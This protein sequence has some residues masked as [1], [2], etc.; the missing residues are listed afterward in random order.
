MNKKIKLV[1]ASG[2]AT[3]D[4]ECGQ[5]F[6]ALGLLET[7]RWGRLAVEVLCE[8]GTR[9]A[10]DPAWS[11][12][13]NYLQKKDSWSDWSLRDHLMVKAADDL[14][15]QL[16]PRVNAHLESGSIMDAIGGAKVSEKTT[17]RL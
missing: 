1:D 8:D 9:L 12:E 11:E 5:G 17:P 7:C 10:I 4:M 6:L 3:F 15:R 16:W 2:H 14:A 13:L